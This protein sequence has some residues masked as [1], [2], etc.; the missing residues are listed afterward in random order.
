MTGDKR[1]IMFRGQRMAESWPKK[2]VEAQEITDYTI[3]ET[4][5][6][7]VRYGSEGR[8]GAADR[9]P[10]RDCGVI[11]GELHVIDCSVE[12]CPKCGGQ[13]ITC[14]CGDVLQ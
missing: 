3:E 5:F 7:R 13:I 12:Q 9:Q 10:C 2:I 11:K 14:L 8:D 6:P 1:F 4:T